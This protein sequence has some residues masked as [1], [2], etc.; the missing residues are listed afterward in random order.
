MF[1]YGDNSWAAD[2]AKGVAASTMSIIINND[3]IQLPKRGRYLKE[4][5]Q[6][7][8]P[9]VMDRL[10]MRWKRSTAAGGRPASAT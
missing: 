1:A 7:V 8:D 10:R 3:L 6:G 9:L 4:R 5:Q 2:A